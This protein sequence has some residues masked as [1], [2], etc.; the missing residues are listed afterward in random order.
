MIQIVIFCNFFNPLNPQ[1]KFVMDNILNF[2]L[3][4][5]FFQRKQVLIFHVNCLLW[6]MIHMKC[7]D[8]LFLFCRLLL[9]LAVRVNPNISRI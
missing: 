5:F 8:L 4:F 7:Q 6:Q 9:F 1:A 3:F 2:L